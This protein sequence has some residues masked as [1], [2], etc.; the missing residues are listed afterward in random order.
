MAL[1]IGKGV[2]SEGS[3]I[4]Y[5]LEGPRRSQSFRALLLAQG[6]RVELVTERE[7][8][9]S[10]TESLARSTLASLPLNRHCKLHVET[11]GGGP[12]APLSL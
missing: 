8:W 2:M 11:E 12:K 3:G 5:L 10:L 7:Q 9:E 6:S 1:V 4:I